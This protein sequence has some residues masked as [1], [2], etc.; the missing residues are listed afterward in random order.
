MIDLTTIVSAPRSSASA[1]LVRSLADTA[2]ADPATW[3]D[4]TEE[5]EN[6]LR[7]FNTYSQAYKGGEATEIKIED[8]IE[9]PEPI[10]THSMEQE[11]DEQTPA[12]SSRARPRAEEKVRPSELDLSLKRIHQKLRD[13]TELLKLHLKHYHMSTEQF[14]LRTSQLNLP[15]DI[16]DMYDTIVKK[17][18]YMFSSITCASQE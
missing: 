9:Q 1:D 2:S 14:M 8:E 3:Y 5:K 11:L 18:Q 15:K 16:I 6:I 17:V 12:M 13:P 10:E 4:V 7:C